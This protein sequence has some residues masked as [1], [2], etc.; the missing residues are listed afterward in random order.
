MA[1]LLNIVS[2]LVITLASGGAKALGDWLRVRPDV[3]AE[4]RGLLER[5]LAD[6]TFAREY[7]GYLG[8]RLPRPYP[9][10][11]LPPKLVAEVRDHGLAD[12][13]PDQ[14]GYLAVSPYQI[15]E[16]RDAI[17]DDELTPFWLAAV[18]RAWAASADEGTSRFRSAAALVEAAMQAVE[19][20]VLET[21]KPARAASSH[22]ESQWI[23]P[24]EALKPIANG[25]ETTVP[26]ALQASEPDEP[27][28]QPTAEAV[29]PIRRGAKTGAAMATFYGDVH[30]PRLAIYIISGKEIAPPADGTLA[31][32]RVAAGEPIGDDVK[33][34]GGGWTFPLPPGTTATDVG[35]WQLRVK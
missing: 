6:G 20:P 21:I 19:D 33:A 32:L 18:D 11:E 26:V 12:L 8:E 14:L 28:A 24:L 29:I 25:P 5:V 22:V 34:T 15:L 27:I 35:K 31:R 13:T 3:V 17:G 16:L 1:N 7:L 9:D 4:L 2:D 30:P 23:I 10:A